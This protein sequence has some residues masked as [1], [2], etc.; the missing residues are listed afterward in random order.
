MKN[1]ACQCDERFVSVE[2]L[3]ALGEILERYRDEKGALIPL[4]QEAQEAYGYLDEKIMRAL[5]KGLVIN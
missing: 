4:L 1:D 2:N 3:E 5:A